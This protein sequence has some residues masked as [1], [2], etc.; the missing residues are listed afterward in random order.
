MILL[1]RS[2]TLSDVCVP[3]ERNAAVEL[4]VVRVA[5]DDLL[6]S[7]EHAGERHL[8]ETGLAA[9]I[10]VTVAVVIDEREAEESLE[11][12][13]GELLA[14][15][16]RR[17]E[18]EEVLER[19]GVDGALAE[20]GEHALHKLVRQLVGAHQYVL[21]YEHDHLAVDLLVVLHGLDGQLALRHVLGEQEVLEQL[22]QVQ[23]HALEHGGRGGRSSRRLLGLEDNRERA[24]HHLEEAIDAEAPRARART[25]VLEGER[26][27]ERLYDGA[28][29]ALVDE[30]VV[31]GRLVV[32]AG[33]HEE[34]TLAKRHEIDRDDLAVFA[35]ARVEPLLLLLKRLAVCGRGGRGAIGIATRA[36]AAAAA[37]RRLSVVAGVE[38][39][40][41]QALE[42]ERDEH[43][44]GGRVAGGRLVELDERA[45]R[46]EARGLQRRQVVVHLEDDKRRVV[47]VEHG[48]GEQLVAD[49]SELLEVALGELAGARQPLHNHA[50]QVHVARQVGLTRR[51]PHARRRRWRLS[52]TRRRTVPS[53]CCFC[54]RV[55][56][57]TI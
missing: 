41:E 35:A 48:H 4:L 43:G 32:Q 29:D 28:Q 55:E 51:R 14:V 30:R 46:V 21:A 19:G 33:G 22:G 9:A 20:Y 12:G 53:I 47:V 24:S 42:Y 13:F 8:G 15:L 5:L 37:A 11:A 38:E 27:V 45:D 18:V 54:S 50:H 17:V 23:P 26:H 39:E 49:A 57:R 56:R 52:R 6:A 2:S 7:A 10:R 1:V 16:A 34:R 40:G 3:G 25:G 31:V 44:V 36:A